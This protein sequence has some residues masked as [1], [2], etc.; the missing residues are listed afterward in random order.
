ML[1][2]GIVF[3]VLLLGVIVFFAVSPKSSR[4]LRLTAI[5]ALG[6]ICVSLI[7]SGIV[8]V[9]G[10]SEDPSIIV[11]PVFQDSAPEVKSGFRIT[12]L[13]II[14]V[15]LGVLSFIIVKALKDQKNAPKVEPK[16]GKNAGLGDEIL[17]SKSSSI[18]SDE[19]SFDFDDLELK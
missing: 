19:D 3:S 1:V 14:L 13:L 17:Q 10:P 6:L 8:I 15:I 2:V 5:I 18:D 12:D 4:L 16:S 9:I 7:I 11:L